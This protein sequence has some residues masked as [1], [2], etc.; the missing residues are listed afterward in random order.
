[1]TRRSF[2]RRNGL[3]P[4]EN[5]FPIFL[6]S[7]GY[8]DVPFVP[9]SAF[10]GVNVCGKST[11]PSWYNGPSLVDCL[12][13]L[14][15]F[16]RRPNDPLI[17]PVFLVDGDQGRINICGKVEVGTL[18]VGEEYVLVPGGER[19]QIGVIYPDYGSL[20]T[21][22]EVLPGENI[23]ALL[24]KGQGT[25]ARRGSV[26]CHP[27]HT[28]TACDSFI[29]E[30]QLMKLPPTAP[31]FSAGFKSILHLHTEVIEC[32]IDELLCELDK[33]GKRTKL[34]KPFVPSGSRV[35]A[36]IQLPRLVGMDVFANFSHLGRFTLRVGGDTLAFGKIVKC[37][38]QM[39]N[40]Q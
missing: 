39:L 16:P 18:R 37:C 32:E 40:K 28:I 30:I 3:T 2:G 27:E 15:P 20:R 36:R 29:G 6:N 33:N 26:L 34:K 38:P 1:M 11:S 4:Y 8:V 31:V 24:M 25:S 23:R 35:A 10:G 5:R 22:K 19:V 17:L 12:D 9:I 7:A 14:P 21:V 13:G